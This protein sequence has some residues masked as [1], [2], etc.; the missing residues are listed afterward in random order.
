VKRTSRKNL[1]SQQEKV[2]LHLM[3]YQRYSLDAD[4][5]KEVT[6]DG[7]A[8][9]VGIGRNNVNKLVLAL[10]DLGYAEALESRHVKGL[11]NVRK[12][13]FLTQAGFDEALALK[14]SVEPLIIRATNMEGK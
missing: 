2:L 6:Q 12:V 11:P 8:A 9:G 14:K 13:Y 4:V 5:P 7:I 3:N 1:L 10:V